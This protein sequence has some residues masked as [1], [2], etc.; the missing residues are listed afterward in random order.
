[1]DKVAPLS[2]II[3]SQNFS[4]SLEKVLE[5]IKKQSLVPKEIVVVDSSR[6]EENKGI[7]KKMK[8]DIPRRIF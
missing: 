7:V 3:P 2:I 8:A 4:Y 6:S 1:M 5:S